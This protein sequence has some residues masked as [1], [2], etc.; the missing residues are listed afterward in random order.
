MEKIINL[1]SNIV[2]NL[3]SYGVNVSVAEILDAI[4]M[5][6][7]YCLINN[8]SNPDEL[9]LNELKH[10]IKSVF[11]KRDYIDKYFEETWRKTTIGVQATRKL[12]E[13]IESNLCRLKLS[14]G[15]KFKSINKVLGK[16]R[17]KKE[18]KTLEA[19]FTNLQRIGVIKKYRKG[20]F[21][22]DKRTA[23]QIA[24]SLA[25][26]GYSDIEEASK[27]I[28]IELLK[29]IPHYKLSKNIHLYIHGG[30]E[31]DR[32]SQIS[33]PKLLELGY[34]VHKKGD[35]HFLK[36][37]ADELK[38]RTIADYITE[39]HIQFL[40]DTGLLTDKNILEIIRYK[41][42]LLKNL[43]SILKSTGIIDRIIE[44]TDISDLG[45][46]LP[47]IIDNIDNKVLEN[48]IEKL[49]ITQLHKL[50]RRILNRIE[51]ENLRND[52]RI[53]MEVSEALN[54]IT[55]S[56]VDKDRV[57]AYKY[58]A[59][60][61]LSKVTKVTPK[62]NIGY[63]A[64][65]L[66]KKLQYALTSNTVGESYVENLLIEIAKSMNFVETWNLLRNLYK[67]SDAKWRNRIKRLAYRLWIKQ[68]GYIKSYIYKG[69][70]KSR[71]KGRI[72]V[73]ETLLNITRFKSNPIVYRDRNELKDV[74]LV[75]DI[76]G[77]MNK[78]STWVLLT[79]SAFIKNVKRIT[80]FHSDTITIDVQ[81]S[82][83]IDLLIDYLLTLEFRGYTDIVKA[84]RETVKG[85]R[86]HRIILIS[87][88][89]QTVKSDE[90][91]SDIIINLVSRGWSITVIAPLSADETVVHTLH[92][93]GVPVYLI[94]NP[95]K[96]PLVF[97]KVWRSLK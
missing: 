14:Y 40:K 67:V 75:A 1:L 69:W 55:S 64:L 20:Y 43:G 28:A 88:L 45:D 15:S 80:L 47:H 21:V 49:P 2:Y 95:L 48:L 78:Y 25:K 92:E 3:R 61:I 12:F 16:A 87:D 42:K 23:H 59:E 35:K 73:R 24:A 74:N 72:D 50:P 81:G 79:A 33:T 44:N 32:L 18:K 86:T 52:L 17:T 60:Y 53:A 4:N 76:S 27:D 41:P 54:Y 91:V 90:S 9:E 62:T 82:R 58:Y 8:I 5:I 36:E 94:D 68:A 83:H 30:I 31:R 93:S 6:K 57:E 19:L 46:I 56:Q 71:I 70:T 37:I 85:A 66:A 65:S 22:V 13:Q 39:K 11:V 96:T 89:K 97:Y 77:S 51:D 26:K 84:L 34:Y 38:N 63:K 10:I 29:S 7:A